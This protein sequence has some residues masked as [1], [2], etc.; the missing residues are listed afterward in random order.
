MHVVN[1]WDRTNLVHSYHHIVLDPVKGDIVAINSRGMMR[2]DH[3][4]AA[5]QPNRQS[6]LFSIGLH[7]VTLSSAAVG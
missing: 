7:F 6:I 5:G 2:V 4:R 3:R 1:F